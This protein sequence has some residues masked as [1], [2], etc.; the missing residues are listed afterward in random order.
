MSDNGQHPVI[1]IFANRG[2]AEAAIDELWH[3]GFA[4]EQVGV[5]A[6]GERL[7]EATTATETMEENAAEGAAKGA[8]AGSAAGAL[9]GA[10]AAATIPG[11][12]AV[13]AGGLLAGIGIGAAAGAALG[14]FAGPFVAMGISRDKAI[15]YEKELRTGRTVVV[16][17]ARDR[18]D[19]ALKVL[20][21]HGA[22]RVEATD[23]TIFQAT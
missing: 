11:F 17:K 16:V 23:K 14:G 19:D 7:R 4:K 6:P 21:S 5:A 8:A 3:E 1:A 13:I 18:E 9:A 10:A 2:Q 22:I 20:R 15:D 12:G